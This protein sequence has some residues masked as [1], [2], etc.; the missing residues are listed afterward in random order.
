MDSIN[1][2]QDFDEE[3]NIFNDIKRSIKSKININYLDENYME[4]YFR[5]NYKLQNYKKNIDDLS[6][7]FEF[8]DEIQSRREKFINLINLIIIFL[9]N[10]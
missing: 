9:I 8:K 5:S 10:F 7:V 6:F 1:I 4:D 2:L 3:K